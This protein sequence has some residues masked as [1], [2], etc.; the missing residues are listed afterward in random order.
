MYAYI[1]LHT[2]IRFWRAFLAIAATWF[3]SNT[4]VSSQPF[5]SLQHYGVAIFSFATV[6]AAVFPFSLQR[7]LLGLLQAAVRLSLQR[8]NSS[9]LAWAAL[10]ARPLFTGF[11][12]FSRA[13][14]T[15]ATALSLVAVLWL[16]FHTAVAF[17]CSTAISSV[18]ALLLVRWRHLTNAFTPKSYHH[19][20]QPSLSVVATATTC[21][22]LTPYF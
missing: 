18:T 10:R 3:C 14:T 17:D 22:L 12:S 16:Y 15:F 19:C 11:F 4:F 7:L 2:V 1:V 8:I 21:G 6:L 5:G 9:S 13:P 20:V